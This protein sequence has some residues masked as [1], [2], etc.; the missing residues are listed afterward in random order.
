M[1]VATTQVGGLLHRDHMATVETLEGL[2]LLLRK[3]RK[4]PAFDPTLT[5]WLADLAA[6]LRREV[7]EH[8]NFEETRLFPLFLAV[9]QT[10]IVEILS[11]EHETILPL[12]QKVAALAEAATASGQFAPADWDS[13]RAL[14]GELIEREMFHIQKEEMGLLAGIAALLDPEEDRRLSEA[15]AALRD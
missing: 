7:A 8:F 2:E 9:G 10:G 11:Q 14:G 3:N 6:R 13:F 15:F 12:A 4:P 1:N 5:A